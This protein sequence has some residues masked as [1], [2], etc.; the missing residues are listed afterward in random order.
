MNIDKKLCLSTVMIFSLI[1]LFAAKTEFQWEEIQDSDWIVDID[2]TYL[3]KGAI[4]IFD[5]IETDE[6]QMQQNRCELKEYK[7][8]HIFNDNGIDLANISFP[9]TKDYNFKEI[10]A[11]SIQK[12]GTITEMNESQIFDKITYKQ[13]RNKVFQKNIFIPGVTSDCIIEFYMELEK[14]DPTFYWQISDNYYT[15]YSEFTWN[16][17]RGAGI[18]SMSYYSKYLTPNYLCLNLKEEI[19]IEKLPSL[20]EVQKIKFSIQDQAPFENEDYTLPD[21]ALNSHVLLFYAGSETATGFWGKKSSNQ[22]DSYQVFA[23]RN[24]KLLPIVEN[25]KSLATNTEKIEAAY[26]WLQENIKNLTYND[27]DGEYATIKSVN[28]FID[29]KYGY[30]VHFNKTFYDMLRELNID[31]K[32]VYVVDRDDNIFQDNAKYWQFDRS[33]VMVKDEKG[34]N[35]FYNP[36]MKY[37]P[38]G[39]VRWYNEGVI[40][41]LCGDQNEQFVS[42]PFSTYL[43]NVKM[44]SANIKLDENMKIHGKVTEDHTGQFAFRLR[45]D[46]SDCTDREQLDL[47]EDKSY[48]N[49]YAAQ[50]DSF[51]INT[52]LEKDRTVNFEYNL[53]VPIAGFKKDNMLMFRISDL[54]R[55]YPIRFKTQERKYPVIFKFANTQREIVKIHLPEGYSVEALPDTRYYSSIAGKIKLETYTID[56]NTIQITRIVT[57]ENTYFKTAMYSEIYDFS[58]EMNNMINDTIIL[59]K[60]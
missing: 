13:K 36:G 38:C 44:I 45:Y 23:Q 58:N 9:Y 53:D 3:S 18:S 16:F 8:V 60:N 22:V 34:M 15:K 51:K 28:S 19:N 25:F 50:L 56:K 6:T 24:K 57:L 21:R 47:M 27:S 20:K 59:R 10:K 35:H 52:S 41:L 11:R 33:Y 32:I 12:D 49:Y 37:L 39:E 4:V 46:F 40:G 14:D 42:I 30:A 29:H 43:D 7:R 2:S 31:A 1:F 48:F 5:K 54:L 55:N 17:Y 26:K